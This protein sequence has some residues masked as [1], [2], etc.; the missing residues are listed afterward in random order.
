MREFRDGDARVVDLLV[1]GAFATLAA[2]QTILEERTGTSPA[3]VAVIATTGL[4]AAVLLYWRRRMPTGVVLGTTVCA[5]VTALALRHPAVGPLVPAVALYTLAGRAGWRSTLA[6]GVVA[7][8][9]LTL[10]PVVRGDQVTGP[11]AQAAALLGIAALV[12]LYVGGQ[13]QIS[14]ALAARAAQLER[15]Q[16]LLARE[17][18]VAE[19]LWI[20]R[21]LHDTIGH[22]VTLL[23]VQA[24]GVRATLPAEHPAA[25]VLESMISGGKEAMTE[26]R[27]MVDVLRPITDEPRPVAGQPSS[28]PAT[29]VSAP[30]LSA[31]PALCEQLRDSGLPVEWDCE[32][33]PDIP[34]AVSVAAYRIVQESLTNVVKHAGLVSTRARIT[35]NGEILDLRVTNAA[36]DPDNPPPAAHTGH[37]H[38]G[39]RERAALFGG[40]FFA[41]PV[42]NGGYAVHVTLALTEPS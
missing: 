40:Q 5:I 4:L 2:I 20:A 10:P 38:A 9:L 27:R 23:V 14:R 39:I 1:V 16:A 32:P 37:G 42:P 11:A 25:P 29:G 21:E 28:A 18:V 12:G 15:E 33:G 41:G 24:G 19:R 26:M 22:H 7:L 17:A 36:A 3:R 34:R 8:V 6:Y 35:R 13:A 30:D 31:V